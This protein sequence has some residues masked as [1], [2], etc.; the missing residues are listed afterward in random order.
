MTATILETEVARV[1]SSLIKNK[2]C[3]DEKEAEYQI[4]L[5]LDM[6]KINRKLA[7]GRADYEAG[8]Y[9]TL[10]SEF[11]DD[12]VTKLEKKHSS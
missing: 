12:F 7:R 9:K 5:Q 6:I 3:K 11:I 1:I 2:I 10:N 4:A 8:R